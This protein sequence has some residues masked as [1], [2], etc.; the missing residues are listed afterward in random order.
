MMRWRVGHDGMENCTW[1]DERV[2]HDEM[3]GLAMKG[4]MG[5]DAGTQDGDDG[6][7]LDDDDDDDDG[8]CV[9]VNSVQ[10]MA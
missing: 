9:E 5:D 2:G 6:D 10:K 1:W 4:W 7:D 8:G 3:K